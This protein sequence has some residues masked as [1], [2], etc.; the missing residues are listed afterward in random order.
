MR[1]VVQ[2]RGTTTDAESKADVSGDWSLTP[3]Q[4]K[5]SKMHTIHT[6]HIASKKYSQSKQSLGENNMH[7]FKKRFSG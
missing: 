2:H 6:T 3:Q 1:S 5:K 7:N 4:N